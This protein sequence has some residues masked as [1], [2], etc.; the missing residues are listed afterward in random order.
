[1]NIVY[2]VHLPVEVLFD[3]IEECMD[4]ADA[5]NHPKTPEKIVMTGQQ[6]IQET[7]MVG[8][9][10]TTGVLFKKSTAMEKFHIHQIIQNIQSTKVK[11]TPI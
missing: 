8:I 2:I 3:Q 9:D 4:Y 11:A 10:N 1:M 6:I 5:G 7:S